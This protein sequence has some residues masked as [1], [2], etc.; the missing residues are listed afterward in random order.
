MGRQGRR[1]GGGVLTG[2]GRLSLLMTWLGVKLNYAPISCL[3]FLNAF[4]D[5][6]IRATGSPISW[7]PSQF[8]LLHLSLPVSGLFMCGF[9]AAYDLSTVGGNHLNCSAR[10]S[11]NS[12][13][14]RQLRHIVDYATLETEF[15]KPEMKAIGIN[16]YLI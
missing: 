9:C 5:I 2:T 3:Q 8:T 7:L 13:R 16:G 15:S 14:R 10:T 12:A 6:F 4:D 11:K 1:V